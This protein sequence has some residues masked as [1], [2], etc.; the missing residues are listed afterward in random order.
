MPAALVSLQCLPWS[1]LLKLEL[2]TTEVSTWRVSGCSG[3]K[4]LLSWAAEAFCPV[5]FGGLMR[6]A[7][8]CGHEAAASSK[9]PRA[10][11]ALQLPG[12]GPSG[13]QMSTQDRTDLVVAGSWGCPGLGG[14]RGR[15]D[16]SCPALHPLPSPCQRA[17]HR[18]QCLPLPKASCDFIGNFSCSGSCCQFV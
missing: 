6:L 5:A 14:P 4:R 10:G 7:Q 2:C 16:A 15:R 17:A 3:W 1:W 12:L 11:R 9:P 18:H 8:T 13:L